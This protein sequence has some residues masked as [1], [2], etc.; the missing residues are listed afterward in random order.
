MFVSL[1]K[2]KRELGFNPRPVDGALKRAVDW[3]RAATCESVTCNCWY[4]WLPS[5]ANLEGLL[6]HS[7]TSSAKPDG[8]WISPRPGGCCDEVANWWRTGPGRSWRGGGGVVKAHQPTCDGIDQHRDS[9]A[10]RSGAQDRRH[11]CGDHG[12]RGGCAF[13]AEPPVT[14]VSHRGKRLLVDRVVSTAEEKARAACRARSP[15]RWKPRQWRTAPRSWVFR[16]L[17]ASVTDTGGGNFPLDFNQTAFRRPLQPQ[18]K[19]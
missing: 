9:V 17:F 11:R 3:F 13:P 1:D 15:W 2:A 14:G 19:S 12:L 10:A 7:T 6:V 16:F 18:R 8:R 4:S 5:A